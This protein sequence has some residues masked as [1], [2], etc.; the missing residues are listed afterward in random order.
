MSNNELQAQIVTHLGSTM[1]GIDKLTSKLENVEKTMKKINST[2]SGMDKKIGDSF[3]RTG[4]KVETAGKRMERFTK[5]LAQIGGPAGG[6]LGK[7]GTSMGMGGAVGVVGAAAAGV[8]VLVGVLRASLARQEEALNRLGDRLRQSA[9]N[10]QTVR[11][12]HLSAASAGAS[13]ENDIRQLTA[14]GGQAAVDRADALAGQGLDPAD[15]RKA[16]IAALK[17]PRGNKATI[18]RALEAGRVAARTGLVTAE[19]AVS[20]L[21]NDYGAG[22]I[23]QTVNPYFLASRGIGMAAGRPYSPAQVYGMG[24]N[25]EGNKYL[26]SADSSNRYKGRI[27]TA[28]R[29]RFA[30][31][32]PTIFSEELQKIMTPLAALQAEQQKMREVELRILKQVADAQSTWAAALENFGMT[33]GGQGSKTQQLRREQ[34]STSGG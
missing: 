29:D 2:G 9:T 23:D 15:A 28:Q 6:I 12:I 18:D 16:V 11:N 5:A 31:W 3:K 20:T 30:E 26:G 14:L 24:V 22:F 19:Q 10:A 34:L 32:G 1:A 25:Q 7:V 21:G 4:D 33:F 8:G 17:I 27:D 13:Q